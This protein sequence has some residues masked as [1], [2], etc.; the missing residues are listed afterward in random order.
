MLKKL[1]YFYFYLLKNFLQG[2]IKS[3]ILIYTLFLKVKK[4]F[5][6]LYFID[7]YF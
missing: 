6:D 2:N 5:V 7:L 1:K 3:L 4:F